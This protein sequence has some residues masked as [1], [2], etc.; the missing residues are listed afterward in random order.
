LEN[1]AETIF[2][3]C[4]RLHPWS[5]KLDFRMCTSFLLVSNEADKHKKICKMVGRCLAMSHRLLRPCVRFARLLEVVV[6]FRKT[7]YSWSLLKNLG[8]FPF[9]NTLSAIIRLTL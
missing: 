7:V 8:I 6:P 3:Y 4:H 5:E 1:A 9:C 2:S